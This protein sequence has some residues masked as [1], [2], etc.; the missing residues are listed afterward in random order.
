MAQTI[1]ETRLDEKNA[2]NRINPSSNAVSDA[3]RK[4]MEGLSFGSVPSFISTESETRLKKINDQIFSIYSQIPE[5]NG[6]SEKQAYRYLADSYIA[7][8]FDVDVSDVVAN[9]KKY[10]NLVFGD[11]NI[12]DRTFTEAFANNWKSYGLQQDIS[13]LSRKWIST[14]DEETRNKIDQEI[15]E[16]KKELVTLTYYE[17]GNW[18]QQNVAKSAPLIRQVGTTAAIT[19]LSMGI[20]GLIGGAVA[21]TSG[22]L[23][24]AVSGATKLNAFKNFVTSAWNAK[25]F[26]NAGRIAGMF[27]DGMI[28]TAAMEFGSSIDSL[29]DI[30]N[31]KGEKL[32]EDTI[33]SASALNAILNTIIEFATPDIFGGK[34][35]GGGNEFSKLITDIS[36]D[37][38]KKVGK[39]F[40]K[41]YISG[42]L[43]ETTE[44]VLQSM[45][46][47]AIE[48]L[49]KNEDVL[50]GSSQ[51]QFGKTEFKAIL[52]SGWETF[53]ETI[54]PMMISGGL[55][56]IPKLGIR[57]VNSKIG[58][59][60]IN[61]NMDRKDG[62]I[63]VSSDSINPVKNSK[64]D[65]SVASKYFNKVISDAENADMKT[66]SD[67]TQNTQS[68]TNKQSNVYDEVSVKENITTENTDTDITQSEDVIV[69][70]ESI[71]EGEDIYDSMASLYEDE[72]KSS[73]AS[74]SQAERDTSKQDFRINGESGYQLKDGVKLPAINVM[75]LGKDNYVIADKESVEI[76]KILT[77]NN[78]K[79]ALLHFV[80]NKSENEFS[81]EL[82]VGIADVDEHNHTIIVDTPADVETMYE[83]V[84]ESGMTINPG[85]TQ[86][87]NSD[88]SYSFNT[89]RNGQSEEWTIKASQPVISENNNQTVEQDLNS[90]TEIQRT[91]ASEYIKSQIGDSIESSSI[92]PSADALLLYSHAT[93]IPLEQITNDKKIAF[94]VVSDKDL[95]GR[96]KKARG[97]TRVTDGNTIQITLTSSATPRTVIHEIGH[98][99]RLT[100]SPDQLN[101]FSSYYGK[102][103]GTWLE[104][105]VQVS[106]DEFRL[107]DSVYSSREKAEKA[108]IKNEERFADDFVTYVLTNEAP[109]V[110]LKSIFQRIKNFLVDILNTLSDMISPELKEKF[111][112]LFKK[113]DITEHDLNSL[114]TNRN[115]LVNKVLFDKDNKTVSSVDQEKMEESVQSETSEDRTA[116]E[117][118]TNK[119]SGNKNSYANI[120]YEPSYQEFVD[121]VDN[122]YYVTT[123][124]ALRILK[125]QK[126]SEQ[127]TAR[128]KKYMNDVSSI[129]AHDL[130]PMAKEYSTLESFIGAVES[131]YKQNDEEFTPRDRERALMAY[132]W[133]RLA[134]PEQLRQQFIDKFANKDG[135]LYLIRNVY[136]Y[137]AVYTNANGNTVIQKRRINSQHIKSM[138]QFVNSKSSQW[139]FD[140]IA[141]DIK[142]NTKIWQKAFNIAYRNTIALKNGKV[143][144]NDLRL[145]Y[146]DYVTSFNS[147]YHW[148]YATWRSKRKDG[149]TEEYLESDKS[150]DELAREVGMALVS[151]KETQLSDSDYEMIETLTYEETTANIRTQYEE[152][153]SHIKDKNSDQVR[154]LKDHYKD[155]I[156]RIRAEY[157]N[158][159]L[160]VKIEERLSKIMN[161]YRSGNVDANAIP[162]I[163][164]VQ[165]LRGSTDTRL[166]EVIKKNATVQD[167]MANS[168]SITSSDGTEIPLTS[169]SEFINDQTIGTFNSYLERLVITNQIAKQEADELLSRINNDDLVRLR[170]ARKIVDEATGEKLPKMVKGSDYRVWTTG[171]KLTL[172]QV[173]KSIIRDNRRML[174][175]KNHM[176]TAEVNSIVTDMMKAV[177]DE[178]NA[179]YSRAESVIQQQ[180]YDEYINGMAEDGD[181]DIDE[182]KSEFP[183]DEFISK[184]IDK[185]RLEERIKSDLKNKTAEYFSGLN[186][187]R[188]ESNSF[189]DFMKSLKTAM[190][191]PQSFSMILDSIRDADAY[192]NNGIFYNQFVRK[193]WDCRQSELNASDVRFKAFE[194]AVNEYLGIPIDQLMDNNHLGRKIS[195][196]FNSDIRDGKSH[197]F[198]ANQLMRIYI[199]MMNGEAS[200]DVS[201]LS[202]TMG[203]DISIDEIRAIYNDDSGKYL[204]KG[205]KLLAEY[206]VKEL[207]ENHSRVAQVEYDTENKI[208]VKLDNYFPRST[209]DTGQ[210]LRESITGSRNS[211]LFLWDGFSE[212]RTDSIYPLDLNTVNVY[213]KAI[214]SQEHYIAFNEWAMQTRRILSGSK[215]SNITSVI[216][217]YVSPEYS[218]ALMDFYNRIA[219]GDKTLDDLDNKLTNVIGNINASRIAASFTSLLRQTIS[220]VTAKMN[221]GSDIKL[222]SALYDAIFNFKKIK[223]EINYKDA[224]MRRRAMEVTL[225]SFSSLPEYRALSSK[226]KK[227][228]RYAMYLAQEYD[229]MIARAV[230]LG[231][232]RKSIESK[233]SESEAVFKASQDVQATQSTTEIT[234]LASLQT[235]RSPMW[236]SFLSFTNDLFRM[237]NQLYVNMPL[238]WKTAMKKAKNNKEFMSDVFGAAMKFAAPAVA[239]VISAAISGGFLPEDDDEELDWRSFFD[240]FKQEAVAE[241][242]PLAGLVMQ[243]VFSGFQSGILFD[244][245]QDAIKALNV[246]S[247]FDDPL[248]YAHDFSDAAIDVAEI[249][250]L[251]GNFM[252]RIRNSLWDKDDKEFDINFGYLFSSAIGDYFDED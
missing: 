192:Q 195:V 218:D 128:I 166:E 151:T 27:V 96:Y 219:V 82:L 49:A 14:N 30:E 179:A 170:Y 206:M 193:V 110:T 158:K 252:K 78:A 153:I 183:F 118:D 154:Q 171:E 92:K 212:L 111:D 53:K 125:D 202:A 230:W 93:G 234:S 46:S 127:Q 13:S 132:G 138:T 22:A 56:S 251:P 113:N 240:D 129:L 155:R 140:W 52:N 12:D 120:G 17:N 194:Q 25:S 20:G 64:I 75:E 90:F 58:I 163:M 169:V 208:L 176:K 225:D 249:L 141:E 95:K 60:F 5:L 119:S 80:E 32:S 191:T 86:N 159:E 106:K 184:T 42:V 81:P 142:N 196:R 9:P 214:R 117:A 246:S 148:D 65:E 177:S 62:D 167:K 87:I 72:D 136:N 245:F 59:D 122:G 19:G 73:N 2:I 239:A 121:L 54:I 168:F 186:K 18:L 241:Y 233:M 124:T 224:F 35:F 74:F 161:A 197:E 220:L 190:L 203:N 61:K 107:G 41:E 48:E 8:A 217:A 215:V 198:T 83:M 109:T 201:M 146:L 104:D 174:Y 165:Y 1:Y 26:I 181:I 98:A 11:S 38:A 244:Y 207:S 88:G 209:N 43:N 135:I 44:E 114:M 236:K 66:S 204:T 242:V 79:G 77:E 76:A 47:T 200:H 228:L 91:Q 3:Y 21:G 143:N 24:N 149:L 210:E 37:T 229:N 173:I 175:D 10:R 131:L 178:F 6:D 185:S 39:Q 116:R 69:D 94:N 145:L 102:I 57:A 144:K 162:L 137:N 152:M 70:N 85:I 232:Y 89:T 187:D 100:L 34:M 223:E 71:D 97:Y 189:T 84:R 63:A 226:Q 188:K 199:A 243:D 99:V 247:A 40:G 216:D 160:N 7:L 221:L 16:K 29:R 156:A 115:S 101:E 68:N 55:F 134:T 180:L 157:K 50:L 222:G 126:L 103:G 36:L 172:L 45:V 238:Q 67:T 31:T 211:L 237:W 108:A 205:E 105:I 139:F 130:V 33:V 231:S 227:I 235:R 123:Q 4:Q 248:E 28:N 51:S 112:V 250:G 15:N 213:L 164:Y 147:D 182:L 133:S 23:A 150:L